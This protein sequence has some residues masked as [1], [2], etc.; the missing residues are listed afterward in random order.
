MSNAHC[1]HATDIN[2]KDKYVYVYFIFVITQTVSWDNMF[3]IV[4]PII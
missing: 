4:Q 3:K 1:S 2:K